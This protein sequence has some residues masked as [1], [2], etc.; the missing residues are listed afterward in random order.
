MKTRKIRAKLL[1][2]IIIPVIVIYAFSG[3]IELRQLRDTKIKEVQQSLRILSFR[4][5]HTLSQ[6]LRLVEDEALDVRADIISDNT[7]TES[8]LMQLLKNNLMNNDLIYGS[9]VAFEPYAFTK[10][11]EL[12]SLYVFRFQDKLITRD[13]AGAGF[14]YMSEECEWYHVPRMLENA[15]W[16]EPYFDEGIGNILMSTYSVPII[17]EK[18][19]RGVVTVDV[20]LNNLGDFIDFDL[21]PDFDMYILT[22]RGN[23]IY[24][25]LYKDEIGRNLMEVERYRDL[26]DK[27]VDTTDKNLRN[28]DDSFEIITAELPE[29]GNIWLVSAPVATTNWMLYFSI[30][31]DDALAEVRAT[32]YNELI[33]LAILI[34]ILI[35]IIY[36]ISSVITKPINSLKNHTE[37]I[38]NLGITDREIK[39]KSKDEI[40]KLAES[41]NIMIQRLRNHE[42]TL[43]DKNAQLDEINKKLNQAYEDLKELDSAKDGFLQMISHEIRTP[44]NGIIGST[45]L[46][47]DELA[48]NQELADF[49]D[50]LKTSVDR[51][52]H[53]STTALL[54]TQ[55]QTGSYQIDRK[56]Q[57]VVEMVNQ[58]IKNVD[59]FAE[60]KK[61][62]FEV[63]IRNRNLKLDVDEELISKALNSVLNNAIKYSKDDSRV[64]VRSMIKDDDL[65]IEVTDS[66]EGFS[67]DAKK[68][69]F[70]SFGL[71]E[72]HYDQNLGLSLAM[73]KLI[74]EGHDGNITVTN[75]I[76]G[77]ARVSLI[78]HHSGVAGS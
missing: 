37:D 50:M 38:A 36:F 75:I 9:A 6:T 44:L 35:L 32:A 46:L 31:E 13:I 29:L 16:S 59:A 51:L 42:I 67:D 26:A 1:Y 4:Y 33:K 61:I 66:G 47:S 12:L 78:F 21:D 43:Q 69:L 39:V 27:M 49:I 5:A 3:L 58:A 57:S 30:D 8:G 76:N 73:T 55:L 70:Q 52:E 65:L 11:K 45:H 2:Y 7:I 77:G 22:S 54:I 15:I 10:D 20:P 18:K 74:M 17:I 40:G 63:D 64:I 53:F 71:G 25:S 14:N 56:E 28:M 34:I 68:N 48:G 60:S 62:S 41:F 24:N 23:F 19:F 72:A